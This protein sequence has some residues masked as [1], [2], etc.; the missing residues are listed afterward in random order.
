MGRKRYGTIHV[1]TAMAVHTFSPV[2]YPKTTGSGADGLTVRLSSSRA[3][4]VSVRGFELQKVTVL[5]DRYRP[6][7]GTKGKGRKWRTQG[8][9]GKYRWRASV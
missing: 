6:R 7:I 4:V 2:E 9:L 5:D 1:R 3:G 8:P